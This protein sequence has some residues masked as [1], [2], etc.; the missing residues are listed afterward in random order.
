M[1]SWGR[2]RRSLCIYLRCKKE[3]KHVT[4]ISCTEM[5][6]PDCGI[7]MTEQSL[8]PTIIDRMIDAYPVNAHKIF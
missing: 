8:T 4:G 7:P 5:K 3:V 6:C 2:S 1:G